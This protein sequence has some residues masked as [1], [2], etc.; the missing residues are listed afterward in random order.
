MPELF[1]LRTPRPSHAPSSPSSHVVSQKV[2]NSLVQ[3]GYNHPPDMTKTALL[4]GIGNI[5]F[6]TE[7][8]SDT[9]RMP[10]VG[11]A[12]KQLFAKTIRPALERVVRTTPQEAE[13]LARQVGQMTGALIIRGN[14]G[15]SMPFTMGAESIGADGVQSALHF[16]DDAK[17]VDFGMGLS[18]LA[19]HA[20]QLKKGTYTLMAVQ[21]NPIVT[22]ALMGAAEALG[23]NTSRMEVHHEGMERVAN[24]LALSEV[25]T[26][27]DLIIASRVH[28]AG[29]QLHSVIVRTPLLLKSGGLL[30][31][32][33]PLR[34]PAGYDYAKVLAQ[35][36]KMSSVQIVNK[37]ASTRRGP[38][39]AKE[40]NITIIAKKR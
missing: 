26:E 33:G 34:F 40:S 6:P 19:A 11:P 27:A 3:Y 10:D 30:L 39:G 21:E 7:F 2:E 38:S 4:V 18:G 13:V 22:A 1:Y 37:I 14:V 29:R 15:L 36:E 35:L 28:M 16:G 9:A 12:T 24:R 23:V 32:R 8:P 25:A 17:V 20:D 5:F 31:A